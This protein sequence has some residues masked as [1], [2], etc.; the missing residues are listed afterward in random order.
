M[1]T[2]FFEFYLLEPLSKNMTTEL[3]LYH[4]V[5]LVNIWAVLPSLCIFLLQLKKI[6]VLEPSVWVLPCL[7]NINSL[8]I[9]KIQVWRHQDLKDPNFYVKVKRG[10]GPLKHGLSPIFTTFQRGPG[11]LWMD[12]PLILFDRCPNWYINS[13]FVQRILNRAPFSGMLEGSQINQYDHTLKLFLEHKRILL[14][15]GILLL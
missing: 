6:R 14:Q 11:P 8:L 5:T 13:N 2:F 3:I 10:L 12:P 4:L 7:Q 9:P 1:I 15:S